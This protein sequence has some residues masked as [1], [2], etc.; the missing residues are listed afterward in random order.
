MVSRLTFSFIGFCQPFLLESFRLSVFTNGAVSLFLNS[1]VNFVKDMTLLTSLLR[2]ID[3][4][5]RLRVLHSILGWC[6]LSQVLRI[7]TMS[8]ATNVVNNHAVSN[9]SQISVV[10]NPM[11]F[12]LFL[13]KVESAVSIFIEIASPKNAVTLLR[14]KIS[15]PLRFFLCKCVHVGNY[16]PCSSM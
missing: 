12:S 13:S 4:T 6:H 5:N 10:S 9:L 15:K 11:S 1:T 3:C 16:T 2:F 14:G 8:I 7:N